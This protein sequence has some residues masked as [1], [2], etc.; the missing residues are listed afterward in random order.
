ML[1]NWQPYVFATSDYGASW[2]QLTT[3]DNGIPADTPVRIV[4]DPQT[5]VSPTVAG[6]YPS[7]EGAGY[8]GGIVSAAIDGRRVAAA[9]ALV[10]SG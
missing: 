6:L 9:L 10:R 5:L 1:D 7:G 3:G 4:R 2:T 8:A